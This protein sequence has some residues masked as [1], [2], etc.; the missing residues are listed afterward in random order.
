M[1]SGYPSEREKKERKNSIKKNDD[2]ELQGIL[3]R[4]YRY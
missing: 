3:D 4:S 1:N 2:D